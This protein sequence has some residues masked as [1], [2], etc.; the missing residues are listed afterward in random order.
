MFLSPPEDK[1][2][3]FRDDIVFRPTE[4]GFDLATPNQLHHFK[5][6]NKYGPLGEMISS[7]Q[8]TCKEL[9]QQ[10][11]TKYGTSPLI[12][13][14]LLQKMFDDGFLDEVYTD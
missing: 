13:R 11:H 9:V 1:T 5:G 6:K 2:V 10:L 8:F 14:T 12:S 4:A 7:G 3:R